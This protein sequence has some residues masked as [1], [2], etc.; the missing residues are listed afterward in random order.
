MTG[1]AVRANAA[2]AQPPLYR[3]AMYK[4]GCAR[5][6]APTRLKRSDPNAPGSHPLDCS[7]R[8]RAAGIP[9]TSY[10][11]KVRD[12]VRDKVSS[13]VVCAPNPALLRHSAVRHSAV[14]S[15]CGRKTTLVSSMFSRRS[16]RWSRLSKTPPRLT[17]GSPSTRK[18]ETIF[19]IWRAKSGAEP[20]SDVEFCMS[21]S[22]KT[23]DYVYP[24]TC[25]RVRVATTCGD[26]VCRVQTATSPHT[27]PHT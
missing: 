17:T 7:R 14:R 1:Q 24:T 19:Q 11:N 20:L 6:A 26:S 5:P 2:G 25:I 9:V 15:G 16:L 21:P 23:G 13:R 3:G 10:S 22:C 8:S 18:P 12:K 27:S 4:A